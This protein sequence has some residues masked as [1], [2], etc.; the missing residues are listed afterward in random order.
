MVSVDTTGRLKRLE[1]RDG[2]GVAGP[3]VAGYGFTYD[4]SHRLTGFDFLPTAYS[5]KDVS[6]SYD[7]RGQLTGANY[8]GTSLID[9]AYAYD[10]NGK[11]VGQQTTGKGTS[12][13]APAAG[14]NNRMPSDLTQTLLSYRV[15][16][17]FG[18]GQAVI[19]R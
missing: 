15:D 9:E 1:H 8:V 11:R 19:V 13:Y 17:D 6:Y 2:L 18:A 10:D 5:T 4:A 16:L 7:Q 14:A 12:T 3:T